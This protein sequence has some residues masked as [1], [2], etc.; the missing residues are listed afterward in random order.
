MIICNWI[1]SNVRVPKRKTLFISE[2]ASDWGI[3]AS[4]KQYWLKGKGKD[5]IQLTIQQLKYL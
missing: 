5:S 4:T 2:T 3:L 1:R